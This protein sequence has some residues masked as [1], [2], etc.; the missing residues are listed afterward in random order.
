M[1]PFGRAELDVRPNLSADTLLLAHRA[2]NDPVLLRRAESAGADAIEADVHLHR[3]RL[4]V[5]HAKRLGPLPLHW[6]R[7]YVQRARP[8]FLVDQLLAAVSRGTRLMLDLKGIDRRLPAHLVRA[9]ARFDG[10]QPL[11]VCSR[12][13]RLLDALPR[14]GSIRRVYSAGSQRQ[15][16]ALGRRLLRNPADGVSVHSRLLTAQSA[17][18]LAELVPLVVTWSVASID[19]VHA[20]AANGVSGFVLDD[21]DVLQTAAASRPVAA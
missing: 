13:W 6:D 12:S 9:L 15:L 14:D 20:L 7:W 16:A 3:G 19:A 10:N 5:R 18:G 11:L 21:L 8:A 4:E 1:E 17:R 2:G